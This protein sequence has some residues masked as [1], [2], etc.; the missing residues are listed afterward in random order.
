MVATCAD[1]GNGGPRLTHCKNIDSGVIVAW[2]QEHLIW[3]I[4]EGWAVLYFLITGAKFAI[5]AAAPSVELVILRDCE[6]M[7]ASR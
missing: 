2:H 6:G 3:H 5:C 1:L 4:D 7:E